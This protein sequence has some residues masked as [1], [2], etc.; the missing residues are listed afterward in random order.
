MP[1][2]TEARLRSIA[3]ILASKVPNQAL[4]Q[5]ITAYLEGSGPLEDVRVAWE[6]EPER[7]TAAPIYFAWRD[8]AELMALAKNQGPMSELDLRYVAVTALIHSFPDVINS[9]GTNERKQ[10]ALEFLRQEQPGPRILLMAVVATLFYAFEKNG[11][12]TPL[13]EYLLTYVP[14]VIDALAAQNDPSHQVWRFSYPWNYVG[15]VQLL[16]SATPPD[17][18]RAW[19]VVRQASQT[20][21]AFGSAINA[22]ARLLFK[23]DPLRATAWARELVKTHPDAWARQAALHHLIQRDAAAHVDLAVEIAR[24]PIAS[25][26]WG[27]LHLY[28]EAV[29]SAYRFDPVAYFPLIEA[30]ALDRQH[31]SIAERAVRELATT[32]NEQTRALLQRCVTSN[33]LLASKEALKALLQQPWEGMQTFIVSLVNHPFSYIRQQAWDWLAQQGEASIEPLAAL[34]ADR[35]PAT[36]LA[37]AQTLGQIGTERAAALLFARVEIEKTAKIRQAIALIMDDLQT[38]DHRSLAREDVLQRALWLRRY[39]PA[40]ALSWFNPEEAPALR[41]T[42]SAQVPPFVLGYLLY[43]QS[44]Q[45]EPGKLDD[46]A[47]RVLSLLDRSASGDLALALF[48]GWLENAARPKEAWLVPLACALGDARLVARLQK[49]IESWQKGRQFTLSLQL[50]PAMSL[51]EDAATRDAL[52][53]LAKRLRRLKLK[54]AAKAA[55]AAAGG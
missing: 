53:D 1:T 12:L 27:E 28:W 23:H 55:L 52:K 37:A 21:A 38:S 34:L 17:L 25:E 35:S 8:I 22:C 18:E 42:T 29:R 6:A 15:L 16:L 44:R 26:N 32:L 40:P 48:T 54:H 2:T 46:Y 43:R 24:S 13:G 30:A 11:Q 31:P 10:Q 33:I 47:R 19:L 14:G 45:K 51:I 20:D 49:T 41:W 3:E 5:T 50:L 4:A 7:H 9:L 36:R 39:V